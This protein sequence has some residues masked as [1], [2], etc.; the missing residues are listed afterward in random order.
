MA[1][2]WVKQCGMCDAKH[3]LNCAL[4]QHTSYVLFLS[5]TGRHKPNLLHWVQLLIRVLVGK[6]APAFKFKVA[7]DAAWN[8]MAV[9]SVAV[10]SVL[11]THVRMTA[12][13]DGYGSASLQMRISAKKEKTESE[14]NIRALICMTHGSYTLGHTLYPCVWGMSPHFKYHKTLVTLNRAVA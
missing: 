3:V 7:G 14:C 5:Q 13:S 8:K 6:W 1:G 10:S 11:K 2:K 9:T 4:S 12:C